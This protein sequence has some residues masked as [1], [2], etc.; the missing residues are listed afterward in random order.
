MTSAGD[1]N[2]RPISNESEEN[3]ASA[4][5]GA[6][7]VLQRSPGT[8]RV[9][10]PEFVY[11]L[12]TI[13]PRFPS[14][15]LEKEFVQATGRTDTNGLTERQTLHRLLGERSNR[16]L[17]RQLNWVL[18]IEGLE[19]YLLVPSDPADLDLLVDS[20]RPIPRDTDTDAVIG[21]RG[22]LVPPEM[23]NGLVVHVCRFSQIYSFDV[24]SLI[25]A[26]PR[27]ERFAAEDFEPVVRE[28]FSRLVQLADNAGATDEHRALNYLALRYPAIYTKTAEAYAEEQSLTGV[29]VRK[30]RLSGARKI[31]D[32]VFSYTNRK[33]DVSDS[34]FVRVDVT[35][36]YP[37]LTTKLSP[38]YQRP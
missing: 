25:S 7:P 18:T 19:T 13:E 20:L 33:T 3:G 22:P 32:V 23:A 12:G 24:D 8:S 28:L 14:L 31:L 21:V 26:V 35:E 5:L 17:A 36:Q 15:G 29:E 38:Y 34:Y 30:S 16:Y 2:V 1:F 10:R 27:P 6:S 4:D 11:A 9:N 37:F